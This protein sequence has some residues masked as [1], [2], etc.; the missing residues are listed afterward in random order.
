M[1]KI[2]DKKLANERESQKKELEDLEDMYNKNLEDALA[3]EWEICRKEMDELV[4]VCV[5]F[6]LDKQDFTVY[7]EMQDM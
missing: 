7:A 1:D 3:Q 4:V 6:N 5:A 2:V